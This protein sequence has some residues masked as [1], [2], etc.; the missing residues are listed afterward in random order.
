MVVFIDD[1]M[2]TMLKPLLMKNPGMN[3]LDF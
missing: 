3:I 2:E 1:S